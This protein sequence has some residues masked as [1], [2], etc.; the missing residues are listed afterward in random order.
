MSRQ[1]NLHANIPTNTPSARRTTAQKY[2][3]IRLINIEDIP[4][5]RAKLQQRQY[6][7]SQINGVIRFVLEY[8]W[9]IIKENSKVESDLEPIV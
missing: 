2:G 1:N 8:N 3:D 9:E 5:L 4:T 7:Q 6:S